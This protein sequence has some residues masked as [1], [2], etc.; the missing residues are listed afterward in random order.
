MMNVIQDNPNMEDSFNR[1]REQQMIEAMG[2]EINNPPN[3]F[4]NNHS[5]NSSNYDDG[6]MNNNDQ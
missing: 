3:V 5:Q 6:T 2:A 1:E 4:E